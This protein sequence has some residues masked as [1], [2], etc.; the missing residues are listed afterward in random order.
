MI[1]ATCPGGVTSNLMTYLA[2]GDTALSVSLTAVISLLSVVSLPLIISLSILHFMDAATAP[3]LS[4]GRTIFGVFAITTVPVII[5]MF[6][7]R[8]APDFAEDF[9]RIARMDATVLFIVIVAGAI[10]AERQNLVEYFIQAG[11]AALSLNLVMMALT[12]ALSKVGQLSETQQ[13]AITLECGLQ[14]GTLVIFVVL[15]LIG[16]REMMVPGAIYSLLM[17]PTAVAYLLFVVQRRRRET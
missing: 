14:I 16:S 2:R 15:T 4:I 8:Y 6:T 17:F 1:I 7:N 5:G 3:E 9:E 12:L 13:T 10:Y 11:P